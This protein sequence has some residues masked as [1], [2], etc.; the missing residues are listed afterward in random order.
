MKYVVI[1]GTFLITA[2]L[3]I[4][5]VYYPNSPLMWLAST[6]TSFA[7]I[8]GAILVLLGA[9]L[10]V[11]PPRPLYLRAIIGAAATALLVSALWFTTTYM[12]QPIDTVV[13]VEVAIVFGI[14]A[15]EVRAP[16]RTTIARRATA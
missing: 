5:G 9:L 3:L 16:Q 13:F 1:A 7:V 12:I 8:R 4:G 2:S 6:S 14:E 10:V 11:R 15:L